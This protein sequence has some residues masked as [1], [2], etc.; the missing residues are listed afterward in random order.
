[1][2]MNCK[3]MYLANKYAETIKTTATQP[4]KPKRKR[5][6]NLLNILKKNMP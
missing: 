5:R 2:S 3:N 6:W 4:V 1:M